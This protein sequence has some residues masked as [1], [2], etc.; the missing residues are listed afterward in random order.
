MPAVATKPRAMYTQA[1]GLDALIVGARHFETH[2]LRRPADALARVAFC[3]RR[4]T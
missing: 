2:F 3:I 4:A 1:A